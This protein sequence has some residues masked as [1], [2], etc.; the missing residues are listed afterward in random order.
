MSGSTA[1]FTGASCGCRR[2][3]VRSRSPTTSSSYASIR[4]VSIERLTPERRL[5]HVRDDSAR[6]CSASTHSSFVPDASV[7][8]RQVE[9]A[10][11]RDPLELRPADREEVLDVAR[12]ARVVR[13]L[14]RLVRPHAQVA[15]ADAVARRATRAARR[16]SSGTTPPPR[17]AARRTPSPSARTRACGR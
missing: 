7:C 1:A 5:D 8:W 11:V 9:V 13:E 2:S 12:L 15:L 14:V 3:T 16:P 17:P 10:A 4:N 6:P